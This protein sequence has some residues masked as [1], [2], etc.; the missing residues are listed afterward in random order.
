MAR[1]KS[2]DRRSAIMSAAIR[3]IASQGLGAA[4]ATIAKE[5]GVSNGSLFTYFETKAD[6]LND[7]PKAGVRSK[8][9]F[10]RVKP[11]PRSLASKRH[12]RG[13][14][15][16]LRGGVGVRARH[17]GAAGFPLAACARL[18]GEVATAAKTGHFGGLALGIF[19]TRTDE[20][21]VRTVGEIRDERFGQHERSDVVRRE[22][23]P[24]PARSSTT[25]VIGI[26]PFVVGTP[27]G[28]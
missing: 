23:I 21:H 24:S 12:D 13:K 14:A 9:R 18:C 8:A 10:E 7:S 22:R 1:S 17:R 28:A 5:A 25:V 6:L 15:T 20:Y 11:Q 19:D 16:L 27:D 2:D 3:V 4:T 26:H